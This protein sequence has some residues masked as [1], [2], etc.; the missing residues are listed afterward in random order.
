MSTKS[1]ILTRR[2]KSDIYSVVEDIPVPPEEWP[3][4]SNVSVAGAVDAGV[5]VQLIAEATWTIPSTSGMTIS[6]LMAPFQNDSTIPDISVFVQMVSISADLLTMSEFLN[7]VYT[8]EFGTPSA[9]QFIPYAFRFTDQYAR[10]NIADIN[11]TELGT[12]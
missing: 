6:V 2:R 10:T 11:T 12:A 4:I 3:T 5:L 7:T 1:N 8:D 9:G